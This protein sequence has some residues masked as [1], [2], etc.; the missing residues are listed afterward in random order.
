MEFAVNVARVVSDLL[1]SELSTL[2]V[3]A[4][5][6]KMV[7]K[8]CANMIQSDSKFALEILSNLKAGRMSSL[9]SIRI[10][11]I[12]ITL[13]LMNKYLKLN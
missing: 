1:S 3:L 7:R 12:V 13:K 6:L 8:V 10:D 5:I 4:R 11:I 2:H 9:V